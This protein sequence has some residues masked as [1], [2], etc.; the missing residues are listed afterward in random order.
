MPAPLTH[1]HSSRREH[2][3]ARR[4]NGGRLL[5]PAPTHYPWWSSGG[6]TEP[7]PLLHPPRTKGFFSSEIDESFNSGAHRVGRKGR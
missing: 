1:T 2:R 4:L 3:Y 7:M 5:A 6:L